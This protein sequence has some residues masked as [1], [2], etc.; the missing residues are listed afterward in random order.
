MTRAATHHETVAKKCPR[1]THV[2]R[3]VT[4][5]SPASEEMC[6][7][8]AGNPKQ[9]CSKLAKKTTT[10]INTTNQTSNRNHHPKTETLFKSMPPLPKNECAGSLILFVFWRRGLLFLVVRIVADD[11]L[12]GAERECRTFL[13]AYGNGNRT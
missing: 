12:E 1:R 10:V 13:A 9:G 8:A 4:V 3:V 6:R 7:G 5:E 2:V 11:S